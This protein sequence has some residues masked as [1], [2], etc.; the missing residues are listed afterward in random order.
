MGFFSELKEDLSQAVN[1]LVPDDELEIVEKEKATVSDTTDALL[2]KAE[3]EFEEELTALH[4]E[5]VA[6]SKVDRKS[7]V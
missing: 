5:P 1:E 6:E 3:E 4:Q 2:K 7:V